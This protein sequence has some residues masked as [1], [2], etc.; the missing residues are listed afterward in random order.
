M[1]C[2]TARNLLDFARPQ[3]NDLDL[4]DLA[5]LEGHLA[6]CADCDGVAR[7]ERQLD[8]HIG[9]AVRDVPI[10]AGLKDRLLTRLKRQRDEWWMEGM[11]RTARYAA[12]AAAVFLVIWGWRS[13]Q[14]LP[15]PTGEEVVEEL[16]APYVWSPPSREDAERAFG[17]S[18]PYEFDY[19]YLTEFG[20]AKLRGRE[21][22]YL[23]FV[24]SSAHDSVVQYA[25]V[26]LLTDKKFNLSD[27][28]AE[29]RDPGGYRV[30]VKV[31]KMSDKYAYAV[32]YTGDLKDLS[33][34][35]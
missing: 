11:K 9:K 12:V 29:H 25:I 24:R 3:A 15:Q 33:G 13:S 32:V 5:A 14:P 26:Y 34:D 16:L 18:V 27:I 7:A 6:V 10:P 28:P 19:L 4:A 1:D 31:S 22:P 21:T 30:K 17:M 35:L 20:F 8:E 2:K 23:R